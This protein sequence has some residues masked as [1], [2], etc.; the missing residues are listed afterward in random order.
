MNELKW[1]EA[2]TMIDNDLVAEADVKE[3][4]QNNI[5]SLYDEGR[6]IAA[7]VDVYRKNRL[8]RVAAA[9]AVLLLIVG[10][11]SG[12]IYLMK[13][14]DKARKDSINEEIVPAV[15]TEKVLPSSEQA[16][17][18]AEEPT[19]APESTSPAVTT[20]KARL[21]D[22][23]ITVTNTIATTITVRQT[24]GIVTTT[25][26]AGKTAAAVTTKAAAMSEEKTTTAAVEKTTLPPAD[27]TEEKPDITPEIPVGKRM[28]TKDDIRKLS[29]MGMKLTVADFDKFIGVDIGSG[30]YVM[31]YEIAD[32]DDEYL[33]V[34]SGG[35]SQEP[36]YVR[37]K[38][39]DGTEID[40]RTEEFKRMIGAAEEKTTVIPPE[41]SSKRKITLNDLRQ[42]YAKRS[43]LRICDLDGFIGVDVGSGI[44]LM[45]YEIENVSGECLRVGSDGSIEK[46]LFTELV[47]EDKTRIDIDSEDFIKAVEAAERG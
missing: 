17:E 15:P 7:G 38:C 25:T 46:P 39:C 30:I 1:I 29:S 34:G 31:K 8:F 4:A 45:E 40:I 16:T 5:S 13:G 2:I 22:E 21:N 3:E 20:K 33:L 19:F 12:G 24:A 28:M 35:L 47:L 6:G 14:H 42:L 9:A 44:C 26:K 10:A 36:L 11:G 23:K 32:I 41:T 18:E 43:E 37:L 27:R